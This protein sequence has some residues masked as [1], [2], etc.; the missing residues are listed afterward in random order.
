MKTNADD[1]SIY[2]R[3]FNAVPLGIILVGKDHRIRE[4][5]HWMRQNTG[6]ESWVVVGQTLKSLFPDT[7]NLRFDWALDMVLTQGYPQILSSILNK[8]VIPIPLSKKAY[9]DLGMMYQNVEILPFVHEEEHMALIIIKDASENTRLTH[10]LISMAARFEKSSLLDA[11]TGL[12][13]RRFLW[14]YLDRELPT[15][16]RERYTIICCMFDLDHFKLINDK[17]G[18]RSGDDVLVFFSELAKSVLRPH[19]VF[20]RYGGEE[21]IGILTRL[22]IED[23]TKLANRLR[24]KLETTTLQGKITQKMT[25]SGGISYWKPTDP[26]MS[27][28]QLVEIADAQLYIAKASGRNCIVMDGIKQEDNED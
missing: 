25:C 13:N 15:A 20:V 27:S 3:I 5:N 9:S 12:Y 11:L 18:H 6:L 19:D 26:P 4:W 21:F 10:T 2:Q 16:L 7:L 24:K 1:T 23:A 17:F 8:Y 22:K 28:E 14:R